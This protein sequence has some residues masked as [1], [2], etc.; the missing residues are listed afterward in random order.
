MNLLL[1]AAIIYCSFIYSI[2]LG[3]YNNLALMLLLFFQYVQM[4]LLFF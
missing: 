3:F 4:K 2:L 1:L